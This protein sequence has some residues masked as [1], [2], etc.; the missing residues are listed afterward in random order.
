MWLITVVGWGEERTPTPS[1][2][3]GQCWGSYFTPTWV[4]T[5]GLKQVPFVPEGLIIHPRAPLIA[6]YIYGT[7]EKL[8]GFAAHGCAAIFND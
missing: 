7:S 2:M 4:S 1:A 3:L 5:R 6:L 8:R